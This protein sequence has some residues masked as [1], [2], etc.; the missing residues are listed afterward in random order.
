MAKGDFLDKGGRWRNKK[1]RYTKPPRG[2]KVIK[3]VPA[4]MDTAGRWRD[5][6]GVYTKA[7][8]KKRT[9]VEVPSL[10]EPEPRVIERE[11]VRVPVFRRRTGDVEHYTEGTQD[12][13][14]RY[15]NCSKGNREDPSTLTKDGEQRV[16]AVFERA[17]IGTL[18]KTQFEADEVAIFRYGLSIRPKQAMHWSEALEEKLQEIL[19]PYPGASIH[20]VDED[21]TFSIRINLGSRTKQ[22]TPDEI[23]EDLAN[24]ETLLGDIYYEIESTYGNTDWFVFWDTDHE[25]IYD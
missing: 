25:L 23:S 2:A 15:M 13:L 4:F 22:S 6:S 21:D 16:P 5:K 12:D 8:P 14:E 24:T 17:F 1:G 20:V 7:P 10:P 3:R 9:L 19:D 18:N 11:R